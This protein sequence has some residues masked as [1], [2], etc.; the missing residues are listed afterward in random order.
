MGSYKN[1]SLTNGKTFDSA[2][3]TGDPFKDPLPTVY[4]KMDVEDEKNGC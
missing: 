4:D 2:P 1:D 3:F